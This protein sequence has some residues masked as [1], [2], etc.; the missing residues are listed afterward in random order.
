MLNDGKVTDGV[1]LVRPLPLCLLVETSA[2]A[3]VGSEGGRGDGVVVVVV[4]NVVVATEEK[5]VGEKVLGSSGSRLSF[6][7]F[8]RS[9]RSPKKGKSVAK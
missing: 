1:V 4:V 7:K 6:W 9:G 8:G 3:V 5:T 2:K